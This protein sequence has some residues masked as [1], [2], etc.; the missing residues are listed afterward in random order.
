MALDY[1]KFQRGTP[2]E[3]AVLKSRDRVEENTLYFIYEKGAASGSLYLGSILIGT[4]GTN[5]DV[6]SL[7]DLSDVLLQNLGATDILMYSSDGKWKNIPLQ[8]L[9]DLIA[10][11]DGLGFEVDE[12]HFDFKPV[13]GV[14]TLRL[15]GFDSA[16]PG[17]SLMKSVDGKTIAWS[18]NNID[19][20]AK[21]VG[22]LNTSIENLHKEVA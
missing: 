6:S 15:L 16:S 4:V 3:Y 22:D 9:A 21:E 14:S 11:E 18:N 13:D 19:D 8:E 20:I 1:V 12:N 10:G 2:S 7:S 17:A 5:S